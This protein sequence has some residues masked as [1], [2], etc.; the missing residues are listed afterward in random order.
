MNRLLFLLATGLLGLA[1]HAQSTATW[2]ATDGLGRTMPSAQEAPLK[3]D[4]KP[5]TVGIFYITWHTQGLHNGAEYKCD[6]SRVLDQDPNARNE[7][8]NKAWTGASYHWGEPEYGYFLSRDKYVVRHDLSMLADAGVDVLIMDVTNAVFYWDEWEVLFSTM[9]EMKKQGNRV[10]K[11]CFWSFN[12]NAISVVQ[13]LYERFYKTPRYQDCWF[14]WDG[15]P[16]LL[17]NATPS[18]DSTPN[19]GSKDVADYS[20]EVKQFFTLRN[21]WWGYYKW[22]GKRYV[23]QEDCWSFGYDLHE[24]QVKALTPEQLCAPHQGRKEQMAVTP[25]Q[26]PLSIVGKCWRRD[27]GEPKL[28]DHDMPASAYCP[29]VDSVVKNPTQYGIYFQD[30]W[31]EALQVDPEFIY[32][33][34]WNEW[35]AG[36]YRSGKDPSGQAAGPDGFLGRVNPFYFVDQY[37]AEFNRTIAPMK[38]GWT[39]NYYMQMAENIRRYKGVDEIPVFRGLQTVTVDG[40]LADWPL[41]TEDFADTRGDVVHRDHDGYGNLHYTDQTGRNDIVRSHVAVDKRNIYFAVETDQNITAHTDPNWMLL[42]IN[43]DQQQKTG[44]Q[45]YDYVINRQVKDASTTT[46]MRYDAARG[47]WTHVCNLTYAVKGNVME[48]AIPRKVLGMTANSLSFDFKWADNPSGL[49][50]IISLCTTGD[51][52][53]N[54]RFA[55]RYIWKK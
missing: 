42:F 12:G 45:G 22:G 4:G 31:N 51:T 40:S 9:Q 21:M 30:R 19:G 39:D 25:A 43:A 10:P 17:Y 11:F 50:D 1:G 7:W 23:G 14:Y 28:D 5:R 29:A 27:V 24:E 41:L 15:K 44:W 34:D 38:G 26:H 54:R 18:F 20:D 33:N 52:A 16:L 6:V 3:R 49:T 35:T 36:R 46:L 13:T 55:Y 32:L 47:E 8:D 48:L 53:P 2:V 37:N